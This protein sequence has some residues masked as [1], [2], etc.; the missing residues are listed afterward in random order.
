MAGGRLS[1]VLYQIRKLVGPDAADDSTDRALLQ[2][3]AA[4]HDEAA[5]A[6]LV[7]RHGG[8]V[9]G[10]SRR[11]LADT[12][13]AEDVFQ[14][15]FF[16]LARKAGSLGRRGTLAGW[17]Y[18]VAYRLALRAQAQ[19]RRRPSQELQDTAMPGPEPAALSTEARRALDEELSVLPE[20]YRAP[21]VLCYLEGKTNE[22][23][24]VYL[25]WPSGTVKGRLARARELLQR[26]LTRRGL[27]L[28][29]ALILDAL[30]EPAA[31]LSP[32]ATLMEITV[33]AAA[34]VAAGRQTV[35]EASA[36]ALALAKGG[37]KAMLLTK[38]K[39]T[40]ILLLAL[41]GLAVAA[42]VLVSEQPRQAG[43]VVP[44]TRPWVNGAPPAAPPQEMPAEKLEFKVDAA[45]LFKTCNQAEYVLTA[46]VV[47][48]TDRVGFSLDAPGEG[49]GEHMTL[50]LADV[51]ALR[52]ILPNTLQCE[53]S[54]SD[55]DGQPTALEF[56]VGKRD[57]SSIDVK[58]KPGLFTLVPNDDNIPP[59]RFAVGVMVAPTPA[60]L[61]LAQTA[62]ALPVGWWLENGKPISPWAKLS[63]EPGGTWVKSAV[64]CSRTGRPAFMAG[65]SVRL[66]VEP[67]QR[68]GRVNVLGAGEFTVTVTNTSDKDIEV[69]ALL[70]SNKGV[71]WADSLFVLYD[72]RP[73][74]LPGAG[75]EADM[76]SVRLAPGK[77]VSTTV[78]LRRIEG[79]PWPKVGEATLLF[80]LCLGEHSLELQF[81]CD[82]G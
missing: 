68:Q 48:I 23:A 24:A 70:R 25:G 35:P 42:I 58:D 59:K 71:A 73:Y 65:P 22:E 9:L 64:H 7:Q 47:D 56:L 60:N 6:A 81:H 31:A 37:M 30:A 54:Y 32:P 53:Y 39:L 40:A 74:F 50:H 78:N 41:S 11:I 51:K 1:H 62:V 61:A 14:A 77:S 12:H 66:K 27:A 20:K 36:A 79:L 49:G 80:R 82:A 21:L 29:P 19:A 55:R 34:L 13:A 2:S 46:K 43:P 17:L 18:T 45:Q 26:R 4:C 57:V 15:T 28:S 5:F 16:I 72:D 52:G 33:R 75:S 44:D 63:K 67:V 3:F 76:K 38:L 10:V 8:M 69:P